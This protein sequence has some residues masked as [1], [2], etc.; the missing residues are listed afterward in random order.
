MTSFATVTW[1][2]DS[3][4]PVAAN[5]PITDSIISTKETKT[6]QRP[7]M[8][9]ALGFFIA[10]LLAETMDVVNAKDIVILQDNAC[11]TVS[12]TSPK[13]T[14]G[15]LPRRTRSSPPQLSPVKVSRWDS[16]PPRQTSSKNKKVRYTKAKSVK[17]ELPKHVPR[18]VSP[19][20]S[21]EGGDIP[22]IPRRRWSKDQEEVCSPK[23]IRHS[24]PTDCSQNKEWDGHIRTMK[25]QA[26]AASPKLPIRLPF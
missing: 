22:R 2:R 20:N 10:Q 1:C 7:T 18:A 19:H 17:Q 13:K 26:S 25:E 9:A 4:F 11:S 21:M 5:V 16:M 6:K 14:T 23:R 24:L 8:T 12:V 15:R 3:S